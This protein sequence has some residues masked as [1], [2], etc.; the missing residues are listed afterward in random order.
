MHIKKIEGPFPCSYA[1]L[2]LVCNNIKKHFRGGFNNGA[3]GLVDGY[4]MIMSPDL[5]MVPA[6][7]LFL[8]QYRFGLF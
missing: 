5:A 2:G 7:L 4:V 8:F 6:L 3:E 1:R